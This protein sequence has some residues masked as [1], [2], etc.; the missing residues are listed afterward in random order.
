MNTVE[1]NRAAASMQRPLIAHPALRPLA[2]LMLQGLLLGL[3]LGSL[4]WN[5]VALALLPLMSRE[6]GLA[7][8]RAAISRGYEGFWRAAR[9]SGLLHMDASAL[10]TLADEPRPHRR[11]QPPQHARRRDAGGPAAAQR[12]RHEGQPG[13]QPLH[14]PGG[15]AGTLHPQRFH[16]R[17]GA[18]G[19]ERPACRRAAAAVSRGHAHH[20][21]AGQPVQQHR[22][23]DRQAGAGAGADGV[24]RHR[25]ALPGQGLAAVAAA[26]AAHRLHGAAGPALCARRPTRRR[27]QDELEAYFA[28]GVHRPAAPAHDR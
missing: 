19:G 27:L 25:L 7:F 16:P 13:A 8:G 24:H 9:A 11:R 20:A 3:G 6:R 10:D 17:H 14:R 4:L 18:A 5:G 23:P 15:A 22:G 2:W 1:R 21:L 28:A 26:A 12:L